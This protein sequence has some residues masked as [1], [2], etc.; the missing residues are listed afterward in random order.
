MHGASLP[1]FKSRL[2]PS[3]AV[4]SWKNRFPSLSLSL[5]ICKLGI[6]FLTQEY[7]K[8]YGCA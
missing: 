7:C 4:W 5:L 8:G 2:C 3:P 6:L 1:R